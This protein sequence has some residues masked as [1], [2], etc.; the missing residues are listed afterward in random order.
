MSRTTVTREIGRTISG[1]RRDNSSL[2]RMIQFRLRCWATIS[3]ESGESG[4]SDNRDRS[5]R[6]SSKNPMKNPVGKVHV[7][8][9]EQGFGNEQATEDTSWG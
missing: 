6:I 9:T 7:A 8:L 1:N 3:P 2:G 5:R 4:F